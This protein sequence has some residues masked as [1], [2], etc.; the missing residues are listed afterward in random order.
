MESFQSSA[1]SFVVDHPVQ[2]L[3]TASLVGYSLRRNK[4]TR[5]G[6]VTAAVTAGVHIAHPE[7]VFFYLLVV[8]F[9]AG[10][11]ATKVCHSS[12][13]LYLVR[14]HGDESGA[15]LEECMD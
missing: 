6:V 5:G 3:I 11:L 14:L 10:T 8:F 2:I 12:F 15:L 4:L 1:R 9:L 13:S 7:P